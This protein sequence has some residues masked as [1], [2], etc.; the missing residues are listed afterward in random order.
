MLFK[1]HYKVTAFFLY[2]QGFIGPLYETKNSVYE[3]ISH[4]LFCTFENLT[5]AKL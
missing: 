2:P 1:N 5:S 4:T 3:L